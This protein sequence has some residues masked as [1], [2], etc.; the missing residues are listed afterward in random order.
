MKRN[1][2]N[3][4]WSPKKIY[5]IILK[6]KKK[7]CAHLYLPCSFLGRA[8][9]CQLIFPLLINVLAKPTGYNI[10]VGIIVL[11]IGKNTVVCMYVC[12]YSLCPKSLRRKNLNLFGMT[13]DYKRAVVLDSFF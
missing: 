2:E 7:N 12:M 3:E 10:H 11:R 4:A 9:L 6:K 8:L 5:F 1:Y 13:F